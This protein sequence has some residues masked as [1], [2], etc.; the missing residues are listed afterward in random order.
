ML[1]LVVHAA[2]LLLGVL[3][4]L[5]LLLLALLL[6]VLPPPPQEHLQQQ[7]PCQ[8]PGLLQAGRPPPSLPSQIPLVWA[9]E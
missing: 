8:P 6:S 3:R 2:Q 7:A 4:S 9:M 1:W 5:V